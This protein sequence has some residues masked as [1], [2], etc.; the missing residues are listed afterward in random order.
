MGH[1]TTEP[2]GVATGWVGSGGRTGTTGGWFQATGQLENCDP[3]GPRGRDLGPWYAHA[4]QVTVVFSG[5][6]RIDETG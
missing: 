6:V 4:S 1:G 3:P 2:R 5:P